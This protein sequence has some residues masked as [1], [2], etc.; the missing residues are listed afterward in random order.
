MR[1]GMNC[2]NVTLRGLTLQPLFEPRT[3]G[4]IEAIAAD[5]K[6]YDVKIEKGYRTDLDDE[7]FYA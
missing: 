5:G 2:R 1:C 6:S 4:V 3:Q 7:K